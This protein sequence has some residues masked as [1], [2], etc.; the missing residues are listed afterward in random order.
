LTQIDSSASTGDFSLV[1]S[2]SDAVQVR[3]WTLSKLPNDKFSIENAII[4]DN[5]SR[6][7]L[8]I[9]PQV[10]S[11]LLFLYLPLLLLFSFSLCIEN[12][13]LAISTTFFV[14]FSPSCFLL[15]SPHRT[16]T[17]PITSLS[18]SLSL[19]LS[20]THT[21]NYTLA[22]PSKPMDTQHGGR[23]S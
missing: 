6:W 17:V 18:L 2:L 8:M 13:L 16:A 1:D 4:L 21:Q 9:D 19:S 3:G 23:R 12:V 10:G 22:G 20:F 5:S 15:S 11:S 7:P 14:C